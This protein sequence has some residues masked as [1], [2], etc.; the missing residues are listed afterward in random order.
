MSVQ[1]KSPVDSYLD[2][3]RDP[4]LLAGRLF[5]AAIFV[6]DA[7]LAVRFADANVAYMQQFGLPGFLLYPAAIFQFVGGLLILVGLYARATAL[8]FAGFCVLTA[9]IFHHE[10]ADLNELIQFGKDF[11][12]AGG[13]L[14]LAAEGAGRWSVDRSRRPER[15][16]GASE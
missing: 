7:T 15:C 8:A 16:F 9:L 4:I 1:R 13:Y 3:F 14:F 6:Y 2:R 11:G 10:L 5:I 12:L